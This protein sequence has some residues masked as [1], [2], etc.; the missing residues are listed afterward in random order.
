M[1]ILFTYLKENKKKEII[2]F[3]DKEIKLIDYM[4]DLDSDLSFKNNLIGFSNSVFIVSED[5]KDDDSLILN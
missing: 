2:S 5:E 1:D 3:L 4:I